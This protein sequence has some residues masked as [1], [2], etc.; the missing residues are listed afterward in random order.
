MDFLYED[1][2][3]IVLN[4]PAGLQV[5]PDKKNLGGTLSDLIREYYPPIV[6]VGEYPDRPGIVHRLDRETSGVMLVV[7][8][9]AAFEYYKKQFQERKIKK[10]YWALVHGKLK[11]KEGDIDFPI[12][13]APGR[14]VKRTI[15]PYGRDKKNAET[16]YRAI[17]E[18]CIEKSP[19]KKNYYSL[20]SVE[21]KT[22]RTHQIRLHLR[23]LGHPITGDQLYKFKR[24][25]EPRGLGRMFL[26]AKEL[27]FRDRAGS[28]KSFGVE[29]D[30]ELAEVLNRL[31]ESLIVCE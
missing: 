28:W 6:S 31:R 20:L 5:H 26:M 1:E 10:T 21:P 25:V 15:S 23:S 4:K 2:D 24:Q 14:T 3:I 9:Q 7:K 8:N 16:H 27:E 22:G 13:R 11:N 19:S 18:F 12:G 30:E 17:E 29:L